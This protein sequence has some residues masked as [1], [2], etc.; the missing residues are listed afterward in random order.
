[1]TKITRHKNFAFVEYPQ[2]VLSGTT[3]ITYPRRKK[4]LCDQDLEELISIAKDQ[5][6]N[7]EIVDKRK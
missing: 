2:T 3:P 7:I 5:D 4:V 6:W 1:M